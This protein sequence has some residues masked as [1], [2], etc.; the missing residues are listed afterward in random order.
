MLP[1]SV[2][3]SSIIRG[4]RPTRN[5]QRP[6]TRPTYD[7]NVGGDLGRQRV[8]SN[9]QNPNAWPNARSPALDVALGRG[10]GYIDLVA[11][12]RDSEPG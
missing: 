9:S 2:T 8:A 1:A 7:A 5:I 4:Q 11:F 3:S 12:V 6:K 10:A